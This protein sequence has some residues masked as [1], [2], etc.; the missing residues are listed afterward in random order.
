MIF[1]LYRLSNQMALEAAVE[2]AA[3]L[4]NK[5]VKPV[6]VGGP[7]LRVAKACETFVELADA[8]G[9]AVAVMPSAKGLVPDHHPHFIGTYWGVVGTPFCADIVDADAYLLAGPL[10]NDYSSVGSCIPC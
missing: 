9:Y 2:L 7:K 3:E 10:F 6:M 1:V 4:L 8:C 5:V